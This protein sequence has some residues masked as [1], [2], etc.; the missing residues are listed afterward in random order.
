MKKISLYASALLVSTNLMAATS[1]T[2]DTTT[3]GTAG[4][5]QFT[6]GAGAN[7]Y[8]GTKVFRYAMDL[9]DLSINTNITY[10]DLVSG[11]DLQNGVLEHDTT[12]SGYLDDGSITNNSI[13]SINVDG[14][15][16]GINIDFNAIGSSIT[17][18]NTGQILVNSISDRSYGIYIGDTL[19]ASITN[20]GTIRATSNNQLHEDSYVIFTWTSNNTGIITNN[21]SLEGNLNVYAR[22]DNNGTIKL[23][24]MGTGNYAWVD[25]YNQSSSGILQ[26]QVDSNSAGNVTDFSKLQGTNVTFDS[27]STIDVNV[28]NQNL[29]AG[30][31][32]S[33]VVEAGA[34]LTANNLNITDNS[35]LLNFT[36][37]LSNGGLS[38]DLQTVSA[39]TIYNSVVSGG[40]NSAAQNAGRALTT[41]QSGGNTQMNSVFTSLNNLSSNQAVAN[42]VETTTPQ[43]ANAASEAT[44]QISRNI[45]NIVNQRQNVYLGNGL[46]SGDMVF[47]EKSLWVKPFGSMGSQQD[48][49][50]L[51]GFDTKTYGL[52][53]GIEGEYADNQ[54]LGFALF[55]ANANVD[56]NNISQ[57]ADLDV[58]SASVYGNVPV[59]DDKTQLLYQLGYSLQKT[60]STRDIS[61]T[62]QTATADYT[63]KSATADLRLVR[64][65]QL[66]EKVLLQPMVS[67][68]YRYFNSP[69]YSESGAG[70]LNLNVDKFSTDEFLVGLGSAAQYKIDDSSKLIGNVNLY[71]DLID[72]NK[73]VT[74]S[75]SGASGVSFDTYGIDNG[76]LSHEIGLGYERE[77]TTFSNINFSYNYQGKGT[78]YSD[79]LISAK[80]VLKF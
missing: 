61:L 45:S 43:I 73:T 57:D 14:Y 31:T 33:G 12:G 8:D 13:I 22:I 7:F 36:Y 75:Y 80:Y 56:M 70:S 25:T 30:Q 63:S 19:N 35:A 62:S 53:L 54:K 21:G 26:I 55:Y 5:S 27:G 72:D 6:Y 32:L 23:P 3:A 9:Y 74:S 17:N 69:S 10:T 66:N 58:F 34:T 47:A 49:D 29:L 28:L 50:G 78:D 1:L 48:K 77:I 4:I 15:A 20:D 67:T 41:I 52:G 51:N 59:I 68:T 46:N 16:K 60:D 42:A 24:K 2:L 71:Y 39:G 44:S 76:R 79:H 40:G 18:S 65:Y 64:D 11:H 38:L 37:S